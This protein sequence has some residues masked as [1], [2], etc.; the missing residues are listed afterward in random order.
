MTNK[1]VLVLVDRKHWVLFVGEYA[2]DGEFRFSG[3]TVMERSKQPNLSELRKRNYGDSQTRPVDDPTLTAE[4]DVVLKGGGVTVAKIPKLWALVT[5][6]QP[7]P[8]VAPLPAAHG[9]H[10]GTRKHDR[11]GASVAADHC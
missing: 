9:R 4:I 5:R 1:K 6:V 10:Q 3:K 8:M 11:A 7:L 2:P